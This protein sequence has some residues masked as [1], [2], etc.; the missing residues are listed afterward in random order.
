MPRKSLHDL[1]GKKNLFAY[2]T[3]RH[4]KIFSLVAG[5]HGVAFFALLPNYQAWTLKGQ[6]YPGPAPCAEDQV[7]GTLYCD[8][9]EYQWGLLDYFEGEFYWKVE[10]NV[11]VEDRSRNALTY[12]LKPDYYGMLSARRWDYEHFLEADFKRFIDDLCEDA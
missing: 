1:Q 6:I 8:L 5:E 2:G 11:R 9:S 3:L 12:L 4:Q 7:L 10:I